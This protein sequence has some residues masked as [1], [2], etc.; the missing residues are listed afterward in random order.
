M[1]KDADRLLAEEWMFKSVLVLFSGLAFDGVS[2]GCILKVI[3]CWPS[4]DGLGIRIE[5]GTRRG[6][7]ADTL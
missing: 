1:V 7:G 6:K 5:A 2:I 4:Q 3:V